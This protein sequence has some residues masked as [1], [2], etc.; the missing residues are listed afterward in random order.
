MSKRYK[1]E[2]IGKRTE[3]CPT[4]MSMLKKGEEKS[5]QRYLVFLPT[6]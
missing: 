6:R 2:R 1:A 4:S 3:P 5:F